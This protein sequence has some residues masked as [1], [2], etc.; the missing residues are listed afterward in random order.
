MIN[1]DPSIF[2]SYDIRGI[3]PDQINKEVAYKFG[4]AYG[5][6]LKEENKKDQSTIIV[7]R[8]MRLSGGE[9]HQSL[10]EGL[11][12]Q[13]VNVVDIGLTSTPTMYFAVGYYA[14]DGGIQVTAS[15]NPKEYNGFKLVRKNANPI[16]GQ[17]GIPEIRDMVIA[18]NFIDPSKKGEYEKK[19]DVLDKLSESCQKEWP[20]DYSVIKPFEI[21]ADA[22]NAMGA[23]DMEVI[24]KPF[25]CHLIKINFDIDGS[26]PSHHPDPTIPENL[27]SLQET[28]VDNHA[29]LGIATDGDGDRYVFVD[30]KGQLIRNEIIRAIVA[31]TAL[32]QY[33][34]ATICSDIRPGRITQ[35][36][37]I[38][39]GGVNIFAKAGNP[40]VKEKMIEN[41]S[42][43]GGESSG[44]YFHKMSYGT[45]EVPVV[46]VRKF[47]EFV[48][49]QSKPL[50][51]IVAPYKVYF[52]SGEINMKVADVKTVLDKIAQNYSDLDVNRLD[53]VT[54]NS[55]DWWFNI[56][57]S[58][59][60]PLV[61]LNLE[62]KSQ[63]IMAQKRDEVLAII[64]G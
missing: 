27:K 61:R 1:I 63:E 50:S 35:D 10:V 57:G 24:F 39:H 45:F 53:G 3:Y 5:Q 42:V 36:V 51:E 20:V 41:D 58:N 2:K 62:A 34:G 6:F 46:L 47:T 54:V 16:S 11:M 12:D 9:I 64:N 22:G 7:S 32:E 55:N 49:R 21:V 44:H 18:N 25:P 14:Y 15:H 56:R 23:I 38:K 33:P 48:S 4:R 59:T 37:V 13:G 17:S 60:E 52:H 29:D 26:F 28:V 43:F 31:E 30:E 8:D 40:L 19:E